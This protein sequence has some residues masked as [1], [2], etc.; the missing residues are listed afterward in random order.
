M[1]VGHSCGH[2]DV[3]GVQYSL[4]LSGITPDTYIL[5]RV[6]LLRC[7]IVFKPLFNQNFHGLFPCDPVLLQGNARLKR[8]RPQVTTKQ[9]S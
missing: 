8:V 3:Q 1:S 5:V 6:H 4:V 7:P 9:L 2:M